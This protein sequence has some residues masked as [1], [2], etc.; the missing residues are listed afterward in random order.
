MFDALIV[1]VEGDDIGDG[2][3]MTIIVRDNELQFDAHSRASPA[4]VTSE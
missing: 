2:F 3:L 4:R 1:L